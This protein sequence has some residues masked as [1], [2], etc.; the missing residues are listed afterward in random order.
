MYLLELFIFVISLMALA[1]TAPLAFFVERKAAICAH[2]RLILDINFQDLSK[3][4][5][6]SPTSPENNNRLVF[7][8]GKL[9]MDEPPQDP[10]LGVQA[11][12]Q[13]IA[14]ERVVEML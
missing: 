11:N 13:S 1:M 12:T 3:G 7:A 4:G 14:L 5:D 6:F 10:V 8:K 2:L 9:R